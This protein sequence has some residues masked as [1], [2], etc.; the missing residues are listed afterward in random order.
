VIEIILQADPLLYFR[1]IFTEE[2]QHVFENAKKKKKK[3]M[4]ATHVAEWKSQN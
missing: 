4:S 3:H 1:L 2:E